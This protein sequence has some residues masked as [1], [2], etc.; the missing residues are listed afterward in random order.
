MTNVDGRVS[1]H[2]ID[3]LLP[4][5]RFNIN[6]SYITE[7][8]LPFVR[9]FV[10]RLIHL[11]PVSAS[12]I[13]TF[14]GF[15]QP[16]VREAIEDLVSRDELTLGADG[17]LML[18]DKANG[19]FTELGEVPRLSLLQ[20]STAC[21]SFDLATFSCLGKENFFDKWKA[22]LQIAV[23]GETASRSEKLV[24][25][26]FQQQFSRILHSGFLSKSLLEDEGD[27]PSIYTVN[28]VSK[29]KQMPLRLPVQFELDEEGS[30]VERE[31]FEVLRSSDY[32]HE[33][34]SME[35]GRLRRTDNLADIRRAAFDLGDGQTMELFGQTR[36][37]LNL[38]FLEE[39]NKLEANSRTQ[40]TTFLGPVYSSGNWALVQAYLA[41][42]IKGRRESKSD[43]APAR[44]RWLAPSD[45]FWGKSNSLQVSFSEILA[46]ARAAER[47]IYSPA[48]YLPVHSSEDLRSARQWKREFAP[49]ID[50]A[51]GLKEGF[52]GGSVEVLHFEDAFVAVVYH[53][54]LPAY[55]VSIPVGFLSADKEVVRSIG[56]LL[57]KYLDGSSEASQPND[58]GP[59]AQFGRSGEPARR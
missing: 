53:V 16:E 23:D 39:L 54:S 34:I 4:A 8:G 58:C 46:K 20:D 48:I 12:Q 35:I 26:S 50:A 32:V 19:Y 57:G 6:F 21:L 18:T 25:K 40:R 28:S 7:K 44:F 49:D 43:P 47:R 33:Q 38:S 37:R 2:E 22:G 42:I 52:L 29:I 56:R 24:E 15:S 45:P 51:H 36:D 3:F 9:E 14:F 30:S 17:R 41:P 10:L 5:Q 31:D 27:P 1:Y 11:A 55:P 13:A 59:L